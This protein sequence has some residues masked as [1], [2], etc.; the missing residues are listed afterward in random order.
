M[1]TPMLVPM[2]ILWW[3]ISNGCSMLAIK[4]SHRCSTSSWEDMSLTIRM[5]S[6]PPMRATRSPSRRHRRKRRETS[7]RT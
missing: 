6:S 7:L 4:R 2:K 1:A 5:N 3:S